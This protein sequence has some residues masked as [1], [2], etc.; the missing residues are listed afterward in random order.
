MLTGTT[1]N[2]KS[3]VCNFFMQRNI[4]KVEHS[5]ISVSK[6][7]SGVA[8]IEGKCI[9]LIETPG[10]FDAS[11]IEGDDERLEFAKALINIKSGFHMIGVVLSVS[12]RIEKS[13]DKLLKDLLC[14][15]EHYL[16]YV[17]LIFTHG[18][19]LGDTDDKQK[20]A[21]RDMINEIKEDKT[22]TFYQVLE[23]INYRYIILE[24]VRPMEKGY[25]ASKS[26]ELVK[27]IDTIFKET[28][29]PATNKFALSIAEYLKKG[30]VDQT[31]LEEELADKIKTAQE[32]MKKDNSKN[33]KEGNSNFY[34]YLRY[35]IIIGGGVLA[36]LF[37]PSPGQI[38]H[39]ISAASGGIR[40]VA[41]D[42]IF[43]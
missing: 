42:C 1:G 33:A 18:K 13:E 22:S 17:V 27:M 28:G 29:K 2:G 21:V 41:E 16:P 19:H 5:F 32:M 3:A 39:G 9:E 34:E 26:K 37:G 25:H 43:Q 8:T 11:L 6:L 31:K 10:F 14:R 30:M 15:Y 38:E 36:S 35:A 40:E 4:F 12:K 23:K 7:E 20:N 24:C